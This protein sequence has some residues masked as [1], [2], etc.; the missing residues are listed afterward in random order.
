M[1][2]RS[3]VGSA[4]RPCSPPPSSTSATSSSASTLANSEIARRLA[5]SER[6]VETHS[7]NIRH[8]LGL[9]TRAQLMAWTAQQGILRDAD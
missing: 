5:I 7:R 1:A 4:S 3:H 2:S 9:A 6:T 8:K